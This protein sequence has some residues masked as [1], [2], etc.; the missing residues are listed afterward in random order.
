MRNDSGLADGRL[1]LPDLPASAVVEVPARITREGAT[2]IPQAPLDPGMRGLVQSVKAY[3]EL[4]ITAEP[5]QVLLIYTA[6]PGSSSADRLG[7][8]ASWAAETSIPGP[9]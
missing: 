8:L 2:V 5:G 1:A 9:A 7:L 6:E 4:A 3:E